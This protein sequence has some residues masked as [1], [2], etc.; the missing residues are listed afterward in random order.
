MSEK[1]LRR[2]FVLR[3]AVVAAYA[4]MVVALVALLPGGAR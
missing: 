1:S 3:V 4:G 2:L